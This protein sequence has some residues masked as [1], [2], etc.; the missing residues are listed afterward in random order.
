MNEG[1]SSSEFEN[2]QAGLLMTSPTTTTTTTTELLYYFSLRVTLPHVEWPQ[3][4]AVINKHSRNYCV[5]FHNADQETDHEHYHFVI[6]D[7]QERSKSQALCLALKRSFNRAGNGFYAGKYR[8]NHVYKA[9]QY[10]KHDD[11]VVWK[12]RGLYWQTYIDEAPDWDSNVSDKK[13]PEKRKR[14]ADPIISFS[15]VLWR[16]LKHRREH[17][18]LSTDLGVTLEHMTRTTNW[19]PSPQI[20]KFGLDPLHHKLFSFRAGGCVGPTPDWWSVR[21]V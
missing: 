6:L 19:T 16:A 13:A 5:G 10:I 4:Q 9:I 11:H 7:L 8:D 2:C 15:N 1:L 17:H 3:L 18:I 12:H 14:E 21:H 20:M